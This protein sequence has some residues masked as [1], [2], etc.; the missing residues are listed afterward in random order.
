MSETP[1]PDS[2]SV[3]SNSLSPSDLQN[4]VPEMVSS[5]EG[6]LRELDSSLTFHSL[7]DRI[8]Q[9]LFSA[10]QHETDAT[11]IQML[12]HGLMAMIRDVVTYENAVA[13][14]VEEEMSEGD[15]EVSAILS[16]H[17]PLAAMRSDP[18]SHS[19]LRN[20]ATNMDKGEW[21]LAC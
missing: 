20:P 1:V 10:I 6:G 17:Q 12:L 2:A 9:L 8:L 18:S 19:H 3:N 15:M 14:M 5:P 16:Q 11:N 4:I 13:K 7:Q 21:V